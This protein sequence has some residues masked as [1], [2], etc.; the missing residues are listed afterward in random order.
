MKA[1][2]LTKESVSRLQ[3]FGIS[4][5]WFS[6][7]NLPSGN[8]G[9]KRVLIEGG[10]VY[11]IEDDLQS[12]EVETVVIRLGGKYSIF[13]DGRPNASMLDRIIAASA[14]HFF[15]SSQI[16]TN[17]K[18][19]S[20][21]DVL[22]FYAGNHHTGKGARLNAKKN[23]NGSGDL[24]FFA[25]TK[26]T[27]QFDE[28]GDGNSIYTVAKKHFA[29][30][31][32]TDGTLKE[33]DD[34][35]GIVLSERLP[36][37]FV[38]G[39]DLNEWYEK[40][41]TQEQRRFVDLPYDGPVRLRGA[42]GTG[43]T[44][45]LVIKML[46]DSLAFEN[47]NE[48]FRLCFVVHSQASVD[49]IQA[50]SE[51]LISQAKLR[52]FTSG[53]GRIEIR[54]LYDLANHHLNFPLREL[55]PVSLDGVEGRHFQY[56]LI[57]IALKEGWGSPIFKSRYG[58][59]SQELSKRWKSSILDK[60][61]AFIA[62]LMNEFSS[63]IDAEGIRRGEETGEKYIKRGRRPNWLLALPA[64][65]D[66]RFVLDV[67]AIYRK[68]LF[69]M[70]ALSIDEMVA[71]FDSF[72]DSN[73][74]DRERQREG[75][76]AIFVD[77]LHLFTAL[78]KQTLQKLVKRDFDID[79]KP[80]R[81]SIFMAY[82]LKQSPRDSFI[83]YFAADGSILSAKSGLQN[84]ELVQLNQVFRYTPQIAEFLKDL[85]S[86][87]PAIDIPGE[88]DAYVGE[89]ELPDAAV[90]TV[91][92]FDDV[93]KL[94]DGVFAEAKKLAKKIEGGGRRVAVLC[95]SEEIFDKYLP[96]LRGRFKS[97]AFLVDSREVTSELRHIGR[98]F[99]FSMPEYVAGL[100]FDTVFLVNV[101]RSEAPKNSG[102]GRRR[103]LISNT[104]LGAS[105]AENRL[106]ISSSD[107]EGGPSDVLDL[108]I[109][110]GSL[111]EK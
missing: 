87:F 21:N 52:E 46:M 77:E 4:D 99:V 39:A 83:D 84:S 1:L 67:H 76:D 8:H 65:I 111:V 44:L 41:L 110:R 16:P 102:V 68:H 18:P 47:G 106:H 12:D 78:E 50:I 105:R 91:E 25:Y 62:E 38:Q 19:Y 103:Q 14:A 108:A 54:T 97:D 56:D 75:Y 101:N 104:Y 11:I 17:W 28:L 3:R 6:K 60:D 59:I 100:Q 23:P 86:A 66:R 72:L 20:E 40:K 95:V 107:D 53:G 48:P 9:L 98:R 33:E 69:D 42:A 94:L 92:R 22:S 96:T 61:P 29:E 109:D 80:D 49:L 73:A 15:A 58:G 43:K 2:I 57:K 71:D 90:P 35:A 64:E 85:D 45:A 93:V 70:N 32:L 89:A 5:E 13:A 63:V 51:S 82:D 24:Y 81:P 55:T 31:I 37:G 74:W 30:A 34:T 26:K 10:L 79:G 7:F 27:I 36:H 88:W